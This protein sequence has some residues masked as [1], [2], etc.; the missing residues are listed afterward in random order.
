M[1]V[2]P[3]TFDA[4]LA[5]RLI[6]ERFV[7]LDVEAWNRPLL[8]LPTREAVRDHLVGR[9]VALDDAAAAA[10]TVAVP[11]Q[12]TKRGAVVFARKGH[13]PATAMA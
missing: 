1:G 11:L 2:W 7:D 4:E 3:L 9:Q 6:G 13:A 5:P 8:T 10:Q 12:V